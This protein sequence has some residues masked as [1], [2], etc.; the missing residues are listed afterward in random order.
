MQ[1]RQGRLNQHGDQPE[2]VC[3]IKCCLLAATLKGL[4]GDVE[5]N[6]GRL[7]I[8]RKFLEKAEYS[9]RR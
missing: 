2:E 3:D 9:S 6:G 7:L 5:S 4:H 8:L 1:R